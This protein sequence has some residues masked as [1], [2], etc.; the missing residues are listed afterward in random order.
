MMAAIVTT[1]LCVPAGAL[2]AAALFLA[3]IPLRAFVT[4]GG[5][6]NPFLG[7]MAWWLAGF[8]P[9]LVYAAYLLPWRGGES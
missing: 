4:F 2:L 3:D 6:L 9:A 8:L 1:L 7:V 5:A